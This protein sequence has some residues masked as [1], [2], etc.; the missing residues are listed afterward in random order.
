MS[1]GQPCSRTTAGPF[2][3]ADVDVADV[4]EAGRDLLDGA[5]RAAQVFSLCC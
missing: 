2:G 1:Y 3:R 4:E 5:E